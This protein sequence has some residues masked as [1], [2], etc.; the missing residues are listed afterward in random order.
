MY[1]QEG[2]VQ[3]FQAL[4]SVLTHEHSEEYHT[5]DLLVLRFINK[6]FQDDKIEENGKVATH[7]N[8]IKNI[9]WKT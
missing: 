9:S 7:Y 1:K 8:F 2:L 4:Y 3:I 6:Y 5:K